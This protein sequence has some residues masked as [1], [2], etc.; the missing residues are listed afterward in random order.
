MGVQVKDVPTTADKGETAI[1]IIS[2]V[3]FCF[4]LCHLFLLFLYKL[5]LSAS[6]A[7]DIEWLRGTMFSPLKL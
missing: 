5:A 4:S 6:S 7:R 2:Q 1:T 3:I